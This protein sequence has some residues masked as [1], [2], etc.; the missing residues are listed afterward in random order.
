[1]TPRPDCEEHHDDA[2]ACGGCHC[3]AC[4]AVCERCSWGCPVCVGADLGAWLRAGGAVTAEAAAEA[5]V[6]ALCGRVYGL[7]AAQLDPEPVVLGL[8]WSLERTGVSA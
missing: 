3:G 6:L 7:A 2:P 4:A 5:V 1:M 8:R